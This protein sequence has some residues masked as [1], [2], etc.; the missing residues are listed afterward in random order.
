M[1]APLPA[2]V[3]RGMLVTVEAD[4]RLG[5]QAAARLVAALLRRCPLLRAVEVEPVEAWV[6]CTAADDAAELYPPYR[7]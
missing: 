7:D 3:R 5:D 2:R 6:G 4:I 1:S